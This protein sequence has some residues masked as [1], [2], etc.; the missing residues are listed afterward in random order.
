MDMA[1]FAG[2]QP[3]RRQE[4]NQSY[5]SYTVG[6]M[7]WAGSLS[8]QISGMLK[9]YGQHTAG[10]LSLVTAVWRLLENVQAVKTKQAACAISV[11]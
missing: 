2:S 10:E 3:L 9:R 4:T 5:V 7:R 11:K 6:H 8:Y 1:S